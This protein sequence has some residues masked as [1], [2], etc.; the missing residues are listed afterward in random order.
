MHELQEGAVDLCSIDDDA[1]ALYRRMID[2][3]LV[4]VTAPIFCWGFPA[5]VKGLIDR[6]YCMMDFSVRRQDVPRL[7]NKPLALLL[8]GGGEEADN[9][10][11]VSRGFRRLAE[12][13]GDQMVGDLFIGGCTTPEEIS[14]HIKARAADFATALGQSLEK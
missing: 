4:L 14:D 2:A 12:Y 8:T 7:H 1:N 6:M 9:A 11:L 10:E 13:L 5:Q 3:D